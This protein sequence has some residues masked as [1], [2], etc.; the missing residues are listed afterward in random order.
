M[1]AYKNT[2]T[3]EMLTIG[4]DNLGEV[5]FIALSLGKQ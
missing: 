4:C 1:C 5:L 2:P 3:K